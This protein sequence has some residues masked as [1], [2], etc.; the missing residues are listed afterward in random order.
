MSDPRDRLVARKR[1]LLKPEW[2]PVLPDL[3]GLTE[4][5]SKAGGMVE[6]GASAAGFG[7]SLACAGTE[8]EDVAT[9]MRSAATM[10]IF[11]LDGLLMGC[12]QLKRLFLYTRK[13]AYRDGY[14]LPVIYTDG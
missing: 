9:R 1:S 5:T 14:I 8:V 2:E 4:A 13:A 10:H 11:R 7:D 12:P 3:F 6:E